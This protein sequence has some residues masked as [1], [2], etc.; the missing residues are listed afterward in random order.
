MINNK[1]LKGSGAAGHGSPIF[2]TVQTGCAYFLIRHKHNLHRKTQVLP[3]EPKKLKLYLSGEDPRFCKRWVN[4]YPACLSGGSQSP[5]EINAP[6]GRRTSSGRSLCADRSE[7]ETAGIRLGIMS[8]GA[9][10]N[11]AP[12]LASET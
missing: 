8:A 10:P 12:S 5:T 2:V 7:A 4:Q 6:R 3:C 9:D 11:P 1:S